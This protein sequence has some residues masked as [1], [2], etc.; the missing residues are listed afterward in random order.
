MEEAA[1]I[2]T[3]GEVEQRGALNHRIVKIEERSCRRI[4][5]NQRLWAEIGFPQVTRRL[6]QGSGCL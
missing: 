6:V 2:Q 4:F 3:L 5:V 1:T